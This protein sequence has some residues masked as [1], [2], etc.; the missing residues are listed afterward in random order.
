MRFAD[1]ESRVDDHGRWILFRYNDQPALQAFFPQGWQL[2]QPFSVFWLGK[3]ERS[4]ITNFLSTIIQ[5]QPAIRM[6]LI[7]PFGVANFS[8]PREADEGPAWTLAHVFNAIGMSP[9]PTMFSA[10]ITRTEDEH[11]DSGEAALY[12]WATTIDESKTRDSADED[13]PDIGVRAALSEW[14]KDRLQGAL[15]NMFAGTNRVPV[16]SHDVMQLP[17]LVISTTHHVFRNDESKS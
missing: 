6:R 17:N 5:P 9:Q 1:P 15:I 16:P 12:V 2:Q 3:S 8:F 14:T 13:G 10:A 4:H 11:E 7:N